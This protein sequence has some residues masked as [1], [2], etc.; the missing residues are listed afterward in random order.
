MSASWYIEFLQ[1]LREFRT[2]CADALNDGDLSKGGKLNVQPISRAVDALE[3][4]WK[5]QF[6]QHTLPHRDDINRHLRFGLA[7]DVL[8]LMTKDIHDAEVKALSAFG[9][10]ELPE[11]APFVSPERIEELRS[12]AA[13]SAYDLSRVL[14]LCEELNIVSKRQCHIATAVLVRALI[15]HVPPIFGMRDFKEVA[16]NYAGTKSFMATAKHLDE[17]SR[18]IADGLLHSHIR[19]TESLPTATQVDFKQSLDVVLGE[20]AR[21]LRK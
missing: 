8:D 6:P 5:K 7:T 12:V 19:K 4:H 17:S 15:D 10:T 21:L 3:R 13:Q 16:N 2:H 18:K 1:R 14:R 9:E 11:G 20:V